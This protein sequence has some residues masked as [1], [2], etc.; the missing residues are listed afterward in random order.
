MTRMDKTLFLGALLLVLAPGIAVAQEAEQ[1][2]PPTGPDYVSEPVVPII[3]PAVRD[4][5]DWQPDATLFG[6]EMKRRDD[7]GFIPIEY[8]IKP[9]VDP[10]LEPSRSEGPRAP[11]A[12]GTPL[13]NYAGQTSISSPP[14]TVG[15]V[16]LTYFVQAVN[17]ARSTAQVLN[18]ETGAVAKTFTLQSLAG[19]LPC[20]SGYCDP[21]VLYDRIANRWLISELPSSGGSVCV[22][23]S[24]TSDPTGSWYA[25]TFGVESSLTDYPKYGVWPQNGNG[26]SYL[27]GANAGSGNYRDVF[28]FDRAKMLAG[29]AATFQKFTVP[30]LPNSGFQ[31]VLPS[32]MEGFL[33]PPDGE[34]A[35]FGRPRDD[36]AQTGASTP[37]YDFL[38]LFSLKIDWSTPANS[39]LTQLTS[40]QI[41]DYDM[42]LCGMGG[43]W[44]CIPQPGTT[45]KIDPIREPL[46]FPLHYR[47][48]P[49]HQAL[50]GTFPEDVDGTDHSAMRWFEL[51]KIGSGAWGLYQEGLVGGEAGVHRFVGSVSMDSAGNIALGYTRSGANAPYYPS[52][53]YKGRMVT[54]PL[55]TMPQGEYVLQD[56]TTSKTGN[57]RWGDYAAMSVDPSNDC[58]FWF[59]TEYGGS[60]QTRVG[61]F[62]F[63]NCGCL[64]YPEAPV[65]SASVPQDNRIDLSW[66]DSALAAITQ[67]F[68]YRSTTAGGPYTQVAAVADT[69][70]GVAGGPSYTYHDDGV[71]GGTRY[72][73]VVK[74]NDS[75]RC[76]S[77]ASG[78]VNA[79][80]TG[81][82]RLPPTF[83]GVTAVSNLAGSTCGMSLSWS[84]ATAGCGAGVT[85]NVYR[86][87]ASGFTL[88]PT[89]L[90][91][92][93]FSGTTY[94][95]NVGLVDG[96]IYY[97]VVRAVDTYS[98]V[99]DSNGIQL[100]GTPTGP[101]SDSSWTDTF[102][103]SESGGGFDLAGWS[104][105][106]IIGTANWGWSTTQKHDGTHSWF[107]ADTTTISDKVLVSPGF[108]VAA[109]T[110]LSFYHT[111]RFEGTTS[112]CYDGGLIEYSADGGAWTVV[113]AADFVSGGYTGTINA[114]F[115]NPL[116]GKTAWCAGAIGT[117]TQVVV[118][119]GGDANL[120]NRVVHVRWHEGDDKQGSSTGWYVD[121][122]ALD[123]ANVAGV[124]TTQSSCSAP[125]APSLASASPDC[126]GVHLAWSAG[127]GSTIAFNVYRATSPGG[128]YAKLAGM[129]VVGT[130]YADTTGVSGT[131]YYY[132]VK[133]GCDSGCATESPASNALSAVA[134]GNG[135]ACNDGNACTLTDT[136]QSGACV[137]GAPVPAPTGTSGLVFST[138]SDLSWAAVSG[139]TGYDVVRGTLSTLL[140]GG[141]F[142]PATNACVGQHVSGTSVSDGHVPASGD[143]DWYLTRGVNL[144]GNGTY[145]DGSAAQSGSRDPGVAASPNACP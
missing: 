37:T 49:D 50:V 130:T 65:A 51:R 66:N 87:T 60:G 93:N 16:G 129:P 133:G 20:N 73:Y 110:M 29:Q 69:S 96:T 25:Y 28:A 124:C 92:G 84:A 63:D 21:V 44:N 101:Y 127:A 3:T 138:S 120:L 46:H 27:M 43:T 6:L 30:G 45:Q 77:P 103:G 64:L 131:P 18:K 114:G 80:A 83:A 109:N 67:Y 24:A 12:F 36:E 144:C 56:A 62:R 111:Y 54:D 22:Y 23:V 139:A 142:T 122:V 26:G 90:I 17:Q 47:N 100:S 116:A 40:V 39:R 8:P 33:P 88:T 74:S 70:P 38:D 97:Y 98:G 75:V 108:R 86:S 82:C 19:S 72:Y 32:S 95:D 31:I 99:E 117:M 121:T 141:S 123:H 15:D 11:D 132:S 102:E 137:G 94:S 58:T 55:G 128:P 13:H 4:L 79:L 9:T 145:D 76:T 68:I 57:E 143:G 41:G 48:F 53:Y 126:A 115:S 7:F 5:P 113:P 14:D 85:Y 105:N 119:L 118:N 42:T 35:I 89:S 91:A 140:S 59:T 1:I 104:H 125:G 10:L 136:C 71:S 107:A 106:S 134:K 112:T 52:I 2:E 81:P 34:A 61:A 78:E 135:S